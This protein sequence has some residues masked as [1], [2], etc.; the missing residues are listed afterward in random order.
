MVGRLGR[1]HGGG[2][3]SYVSHLQSSPCPDEFLVP[4]YKNFDLGVLCRLDIPFR[5]ND[6]LQERHVH[7]STAPKHVFSF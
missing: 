2:S 7:K 1:E 3:Q 6:T 5:L 4:Q